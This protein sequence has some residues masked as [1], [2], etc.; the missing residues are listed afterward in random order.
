MPQKDYSQ[1][2][3]NRAALINHTVALEFGVNANDLIMDRRRGSPQTAMARQIAIYLFQS[4]F[5]D[6][7]SRVGRVFKRHSTTVRH[8][9]E[10]VEVCREDPVFDRRISV[11]EDFLRQ[12]PIPADCR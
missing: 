8:A 3:T 2:D 1:Y 6:N 9:C 7:M 11:L 10:T 4:I 12:A 5:T